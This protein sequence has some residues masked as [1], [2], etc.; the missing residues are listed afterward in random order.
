V[1]S[2]DLSVALSKTTGVRASSRTVAGTF[3]QRRRRVGLLFVAP[4][5]AVLMAILGY[6]ILRSLILAMQHVRLAGG[7][8][9]LHWIGW[10]NYQALFADDTFLTALRS[11]VI[12]SLGEVVMV[13]IL[14]LGAALL[15]NHRFGRF[16][17][18]R[19]LLIIPWAIAPVA[20]AV[21]WKWILNSNYGV[22][23][24]VLKSLGVIDHYVVWLGSPT[25]A[26]TLLLLVDVWKS[27]P[28]IALLFLAGL[29]RIPKILYRAAVLD[30]ANSWAQFRF[31]TL[32]SLRTTIAIAVVLQTIWSLRVF[33]L[34]FVLTRGGPADGTVLLNFLAYR[35][36]FDFLNL[37]SGAAIA[38]VIFAMSFVLAIL[39]I[40]LL[41]PRHREIKA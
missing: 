14:S 15:L 12:F 25:R 32:P 3:E 22:L 11:T 8:L 5:L 33:D 28:F 4:A 40:W 31:I 23:N 2:L 16:G 36:T 9:H 35:V 7:H 27:V 41:Q 38:N 39:Y 29:Q 1:T 20:N 13:T 10:A 17:I 30:G 26:L 18:L 24:A 37:G 6:P 19:V 34:V 21:L